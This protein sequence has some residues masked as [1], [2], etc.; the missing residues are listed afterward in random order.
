[1]KQIFKGR[2][3]ENGDLIK[4]GVAEFEGRIFII[5]MIRQYT[6]DNKEVITPIE[7]EID[8]ETL[9]LLEQEK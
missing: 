6:L 9:M 3:I 5:T 7:R 2:C 8:P 1:M 4:G